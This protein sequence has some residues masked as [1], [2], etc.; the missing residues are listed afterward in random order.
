MSD[1][2]GAPPKAER[3]MIWID[4]VGGYLACMAPV[5]TIGQAIPGSHVD[6]PLQADISRRHAIVRRI[7]EGYAIDPLHDVSVNGKPISEAAYLVDGDEI[8]LGEKVKLRFVKKHSLSASARLDFVSRHRT[9]PSADGIL[10]MAES[11][12]IGPGAASHI[13]CRDWPHEIVLFRRSEGLGC[14]SPGPLTIDGRRFE[15]KAALPFGAHLGGE[16]VSLTLE[17]LASPEI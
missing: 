9:Q 5:V 8:A 12:V 1:E 13:L 2:S 11:L 17:R 16:S 7:G 15:G 4:G 3:F 6:I 14:R 10:L